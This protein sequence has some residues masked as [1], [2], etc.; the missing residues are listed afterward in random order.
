MNQEN[1]NPLL[2]KIGGILASRKLRSTVRAQLVQ[3][4]QKAERIPDSTLQ[5]VYLDNIF[6][7]EMKTQ[8]ENVSKNIEAL[9]NREN[10]QTLTTS[11]REKVR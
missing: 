11:P 4:L 1:L 5:K 2:E 8:G 3:I 9:K 6:S 10:M 7:T